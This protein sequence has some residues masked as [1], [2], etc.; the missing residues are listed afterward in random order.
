M[1]S[2]IRDWTFIS[3]FQK[4]LHI[5]TYCLH[6][7]VFHFCYCS[8]SSRE[9]I[10]IR[11]EIISNCFCMKRMENENSLRHVTSPMSDSDDVI[12]SK[13]IEHMSNMTCK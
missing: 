4:L 13:F 11:A 7:S 5:S 1:F 8:P 9:E 3:Y 2:S 10:L 6:V 12:Q